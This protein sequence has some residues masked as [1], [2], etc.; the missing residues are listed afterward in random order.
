MS[1]TSSRPESVTSTSSTSSTI[2]R[3]WSAVVE[4]FSF[5]PVNGED[6][7]TATVLRCKYSG[8][9]DLLEDMEGFEDADLMWGGVVVGGGVT[10]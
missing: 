5:L 1:T 7:A 6:A 3:C 10:W 4:L 2:S 8:D 9:E